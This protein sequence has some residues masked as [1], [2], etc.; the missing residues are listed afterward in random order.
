VEDR[1]QQSYAT[2]DDHVQPSLSNGI[3][4]HR[5]GAELVIQVMRPGSIHV[6]GQHSL[7]LAP[8]E[9]QYPIQQLTADGADPSLGDRVRPGYPH[10][11]A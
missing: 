10:R 5:V 3:A 4:G 2:A 1:L 7:K 9:D 6:L 11:G 8:V